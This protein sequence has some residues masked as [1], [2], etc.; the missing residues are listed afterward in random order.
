MLEFYYKFVYTLNTFNIYQLA[1][2]TPC[3]N[4]P[5]SWVENYI[6][7]CKSIE[8]LLNDEEIVWILVNDGSIPSIELKLIEKIKSS[9]KHFK[10]FSLDQNKGKGFATRYGAQQIE[11]AAYM[12]T[13][14][15]FPY[16]N[17]DFV[18]VYNSVKAGNDLVIAKR[19]EQYYQQISKSRTWISQR[20]KSIVKI[21]F[22]IP[23][24]DTQAGLK[25]LS[26]AGREVL[27]QTKVNRYLFDL[28]L[29]KLAAKKRLKISE[30]AVNLKEGI[31]LTDVSY[32]ILFAELLN[33]FKILFS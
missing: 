10:Y 17:E 3:F 23:T 26:M 5:S 19:S 27:L 32:K 31:T 11:A 16:Q 6:S 33:L 28:E 12:Y 20:F 18:A 13:D 14:I 21:L 8:N 15:D 30:V 9:L 25:G 29:V 1:V 4:P 7:S 2:I 22:K 24:T